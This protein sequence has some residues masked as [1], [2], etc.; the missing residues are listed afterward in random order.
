MVARDASAAGPFSCIVVTINGVSRAHDGAAGAQALPAKF[1][2][3]ICAK[4]F[5][6]PALPQIF[7]Q[8]ALQL[9]SHQAP[10]FQCIAV[11]TLPSPACWVPARAFAQAQTFIEVFAFRPG[12]CTSHMLRAVT[13]TATCA[14]F[15]ALRN[16]YT[17]EYPTPLQPQVQRPRFG[18]VSAVLADGI[19]AAS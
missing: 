16:G 5:A 8:S 14:F 11:M 17:S 19:D 1:A 9:A 7:V 3:E 10:C 18:A 6:A 13:I 2:Q 12:P 4:Q 15:A